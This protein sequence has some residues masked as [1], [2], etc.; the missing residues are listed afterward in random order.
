M[1]VVII[2][3]TGRLGKRI[4][5]ELVSRGH[6]VLGVNRA[7]RWQI[8]LQEARS[9]LD[10]MDDHDTPMNRVFMKGHP[11]ADESGMVTFPNVNPHNEMVDLVLASRG[12]EANL[13]VS[14]MA[15]EMARQALEI[16]R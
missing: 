16:G 8:S 15:I 14:K 4:A 5:R 13:E 11:Q 1:R 2:G 7:D 9:I 12:Y 10:S 6:D 3:I